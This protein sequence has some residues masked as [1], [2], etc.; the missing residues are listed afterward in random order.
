[1]RVTGESQGALTKKIGQLISLKK[2]SKKIQN[3]FYRIVVSLLIGS[4]MFV[5]GL[6][7]P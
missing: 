1:M 6:I 7:R 3:L 2:P 5:Q 4:I